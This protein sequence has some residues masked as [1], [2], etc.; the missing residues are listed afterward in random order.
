[1]KVLVSVPENTLIIPAAARKLAAASISANT[2]RIYAGVLHKLDAWLA[3]RRL[4]DA[5]L[6]VYLSELF[7]AGLSPSTAGQTTAAARFRAKLTGEA[8]PVGPATTRVLAGFR[9]KGKGRGR[10]QVD[11]LRWEQA[12][13]T[14]AVT[15]N[16][17]VTMADLRDAA[18]IAIMSDGML[19][20]GECAALDVADL[21]VEPD[22]TGHITIRSSKTDQEGEGAVQFVGAPT[23]SRIRTWLDAASIKRGPMFRAVRGGRG[24]SGRDAERRPMEVPGDARQV[25]SRPARQPWRYRPPSIREVT[26]AAASRFPPPESAGIGRPRAPR[27][28]H[29]C[30][31]SRRV[32][33]GAS[34]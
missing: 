13:V 26:P 8:D 21:G 17:T 33:S 15:A 11:G 16:G 19:R 4:D 9:R 32:D 30:E 5:A 18:M 34:R 31:P 28:R 14:A 7:E 23:V 22:G 1:M 10:G 6:A 3:G 20:V 29:R 12:D 24:R 27:F 2:H 25:R